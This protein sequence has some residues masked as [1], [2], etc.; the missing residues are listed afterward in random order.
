[1][2]LNLPHLPFAAGARARAQQVN[3]VFDVL[4]AALNTTSGGQI[5][6]ADSSAEPRPVSMSGDVTINAAGATAIGAGKVTTAKI[7]D[8]GITTA[9]LADNAATSDKVA[10]SIHI[11]NLSTGN[12]TTY[13][14]L[15]SR[16]PTAGWWLVNVDCGFNIATKTYGQI[17]ITVG[18][19][20][21][22]VSPQ[23]GVEAVDGIAGQLSLAAIVAVSGS[24]AVAVQARRES[25]GGLCV[26]NGGMMSMV[27]VI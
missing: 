1:M 6:V 12:V 23:L 27:R 4:K 16:T 2:A 9:K 10:L 26:A 24:Q 15:A 11:D 22:R 8:G 18:G 25:G 5:I 13:T 14:T 19:T 7:P 21:V 3:D 17:R 20:A